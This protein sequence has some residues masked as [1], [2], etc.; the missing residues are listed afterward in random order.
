MKKRSVNVFP[1]F[2]KRRIN[3]KLLFLGTFENSANEVG[4]KARTCQLVHKLFQS[5]NIEKD[6]LWVKKTCKVG[7][8]CLIV[9]NGVIEVITYINIVIQQQV[10]LMQ[11]RATLT[12]VS[13]KLMQVGKQTLITQKKRFHRS[14][15]LTE[16]RPARK[17]D[18]LG[19]RRN[20]EIRNIKVKNFL[21]VFSY[22]SQ[23]LKLGPSC[24]YS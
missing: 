2:S 11:V 9:R 22:I 6:K 24:L 4:N 1:L 15:F 7:K 5:E 10:R 23:K 16:I 19:F 3:K 21:F 17:Q 18:L 8:K 14:L 13:P 20:P 12:Q